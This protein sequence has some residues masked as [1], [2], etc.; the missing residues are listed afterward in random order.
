MSV[1]TLLNMGQQVVV[2]S[3][4]KSYATVLAGSNS[5]PPTLILRFSLHGTYTVVW[6]PLH[7]RNNR[8]SQLL[9]RRRGHSLLMPSRQE[10]TINSSIGALN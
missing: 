7:A 1:G 6:N 10:R 2:T 4:R 5:T 9:W 8:S 3:E